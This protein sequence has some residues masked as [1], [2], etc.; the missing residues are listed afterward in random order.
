MTYTAIR[1]MRSVSSRNSAAIRQE[2]LI[3]PIEP[4]RDCRD[5]L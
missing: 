3:T 2:D 4:C 1:G 5:L